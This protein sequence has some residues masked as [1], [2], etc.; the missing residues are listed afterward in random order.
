MYS[1]TDGWTNV[2]VWWIGVRIAPVNGSGTTPA[3]TSLVS[4]L[5]AER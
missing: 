4:N 1:S 5:M 3:W 2:V